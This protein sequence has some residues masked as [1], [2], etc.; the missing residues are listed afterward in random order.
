MLGDDTIL[1]CAKQRV[2]SCSG[3]Q[4]RPCFA[5]AKQV[6]TAGSVAWLTISEGRK[7]GEDSEQDAIYCF[8][9]PWPCEGSRSRSTSCFCFAYCFAVLP[10]CVLRSHS[11]ARKKYLVQSNCKPSNTSNKRIRTQLKP[12]FAQAYQTDGIACVARDCYA[13]DPS[14]LG[15]DGPMNCFLVHAKQSQFSCW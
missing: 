7:K 1:L 15:T 6:L 2:A 11:E 9:W 3:S 12:F 14:L 10:S 8:T 5:H 13:R 4:L